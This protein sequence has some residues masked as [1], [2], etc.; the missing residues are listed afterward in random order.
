MKSFKK[1]LDEYYFQKDGDGDRKNMRLDP[2]NV[3]FRGQKAEVFLYLPKEKIDNCKVPPHF[4]AVVENYFENKLY[5]KQKPNKVKPMS[6]A[7]S[8]NC[9]EKHGEVRH[10]VVQWIAYKGKANSIITKYCINISVLPNKE[11]NKEA[12][13]NCGHVIVRAMKAE[14]YFPCKAKKQF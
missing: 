10:R 12:K 7:T 13:F 4:K 2:I 9:F 6:L 1:L 14:N 3:T 8:S 5:E 11:L